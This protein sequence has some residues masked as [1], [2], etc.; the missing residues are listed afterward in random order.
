MYA[1]KVS[2]QVVDEKTGEVAKS[3]TGGAPIEM[4]S[5][6]Y[7]LFDSADDG[8]EAANKLYEVLTHAMH[9]GNVF[10]RVGHE[11]KKK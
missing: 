1:I 10:H 3:R 11:I 9:L 4:G 7:P 2:I 6:Y 8:H 5:W